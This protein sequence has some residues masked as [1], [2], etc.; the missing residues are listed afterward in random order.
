MV[1]GSL[2]AS[3]GDSVKGHQFQ[4]C[5]VLPRLFCNSTVLQIP[6]SLI[7]V[8]LFLQGRKLVRVLQAGFH[9][10]TSFPGN[11]RYLPILDLFQSGRPSRWLLKFPGGWTTDQ[12]KSVTC[13]N[14]VQMLNGELGVDLLKGLVARRSM[15]KMN[16]EEQILTKCR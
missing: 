13:P 7:S 4:S 8:P 16:L 5:H 10:R 15:S 12:S 11:Q 9:L 1:Y 3:E 6:P 2:L 14:A